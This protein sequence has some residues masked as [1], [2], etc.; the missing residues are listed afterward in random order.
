MREAEVVDVFEAWLRAQ[1]WTVQRE[2]RFVDLLAEHADGRLLYVEAKGKTTSPGLDV[3]TL[4][5]QLLRRI[6]P[7]EPHARYA[8]VVPSVL[9]RA[10]ARV[11]RRVREQLR[12]DVYLVDDDRHVEAV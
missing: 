12:I 4:Y 10:V 1:G 6:D 9:E 5:G 7:D 2:V 11:P 3:D 8:V